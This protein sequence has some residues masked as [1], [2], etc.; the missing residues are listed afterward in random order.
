MEEVSIF[1]IAPPRKEE[2]PWPGKRSIKIIGKKKML[3]V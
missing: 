3:T 2:K 1:H